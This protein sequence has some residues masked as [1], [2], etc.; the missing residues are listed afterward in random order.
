MDKNFQALAQMTNGGPFRVVVGQVTDVNFE[1]KSWSDETGSLKATDLIGSECYTSIEV[2]WIGG[3]Q[4]IKFPPTLG[5]VTGQI[6]DGAFVFAVIPQKSK[7][8][9]MKDIPDQMEV[10]GLGL[11]IH[12]DSF[13]ADLAKYPGN[14]NPR[15][16]AAA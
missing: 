16:A 4:K 9:M 6:E 5:D 12:D 1:T 11:T 2:S 3:N 13:A 15:R 10:L 8:G 14:T 7:R